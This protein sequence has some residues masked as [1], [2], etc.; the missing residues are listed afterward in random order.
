MAELICLCGPTLSHVRQ[1]VYRNIQGN[2]I[3]FNNVP[4]LYCDSCGETLFTAK[5]IKTMDDLIRNNPGTLIL[6]YSSTEIKF[7]FKE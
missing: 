7:A 3:K 5:T 4:V 1:V 2:E 6:E